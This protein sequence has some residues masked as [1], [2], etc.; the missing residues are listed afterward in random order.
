MTRDTQLEKFS[1]VNAMMKLN[2]HVSYSMVTEDCKKYKTKNVLAK[3]LIDRFLHTV[4]ELVHVSGTQFILE[5]GCGQ[6][7]VTDFLLQYIPNLS[8]VGIDIN[9]ELVKG[10]VAKDIRNSVFVGDVYNLPFCEKIFDMVI[11][12]EVLEHLTDPSCALRELSRV[13]KSCCILSVPNEPYFQLMALLRGKHVKRLG[14]HPDHVNNW[15]KHRFLEMIRSEFT[16]L[17]IRQSFPWV[18]V[19]CRK[20]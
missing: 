18:V 20:R 12:L 13:S 17:Q 10:S 9:L 5:A 4:S 8:I 7:F 3:W 15:G 14:N 11:C 6:G 19:L 1:G 16:I 2:E